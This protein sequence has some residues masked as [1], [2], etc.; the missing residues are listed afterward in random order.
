VRALLF[1]LLLAEWAELEIEAVAAFWIDRKTPL[2]AEADWRETGKCFVF[3]VVP[4]AIR[5]F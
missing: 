2:L 1:D 5:W 3:V 4:F